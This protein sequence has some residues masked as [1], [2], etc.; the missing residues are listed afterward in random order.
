MHRKVSQFGLQMLLAGIVPVVALVLA[1]V[2][3]GQ[4]DQQETHGQQPG[5]PATPPQQQPATPPRPSSNPDASQDPSQESSSKKAQPPDDPGPGKPPADAA[6]KSKPGVLPPEDD[7]AWDPF[8]A[9]QD[10]DVGMFYLHKG[11][12]DAAITRFEDAIRLRANFAKPRLLLAEAYEKK[13]DPS[14]ALRYYKEYLQVLPNAP[15]AKKIREKI[16][17]LSKK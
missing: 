5:Q 8:H 13:N 12:V 4:Q 6:K 3:Y 10:V 17:K 7:P 11:D 15:D 9:Q 16:E 14:E 1:P 2:G